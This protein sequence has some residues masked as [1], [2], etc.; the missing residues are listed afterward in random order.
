MVLCDGTTGG[1]GSS[2]PFSV[3]FDNTNVQNNPLLIKINSSQPV[4][5]PGGLSI[6]V[7]ID[8]APVIGGTGI[9]QNSSDY[10]V[11]IPN[12]LS[13]G[14]IQLQAGAYIILWKCIYQSPEYVI[15]GLLEACG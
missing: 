2:G 4:T 14:S 1:G 10:T 5:K 3:T 7:R 8:T 13:T 11:F 15:E 9:S 12:G 6:R